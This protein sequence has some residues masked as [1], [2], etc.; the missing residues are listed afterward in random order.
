MRMKDKFYRALFVL[1]LVCI[2]LFLNIIRSKSHAL[3]LGSEFGSTP[4]LYTHTQ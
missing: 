3:E 4:L 1:F 2:K